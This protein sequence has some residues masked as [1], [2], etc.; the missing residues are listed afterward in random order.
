MSDK[1]NTPENQPG[2]IPPHGGYETLK[3]YQMSVLVYERFEG[4]GLG[5]AKPAALIIVLLALVVFVAVRTIGGR[6]R[7]DGQG[8]SA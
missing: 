5:A 4:L 2:F 8:R 7:S 3:S 6:E 1:T